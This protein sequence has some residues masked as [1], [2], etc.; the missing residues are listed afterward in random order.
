MDNSNLKNTY[1]EAWR[2]L[3]KKELKLE[4]LDTQT[5][6]LE[7][8]LQYNPYFDPGKVELESHIPNSMPALSIGHR[9]VDLPEQLINEYLKVLVQYDLQVFSVEYERKVDWKTLLEGIYPE[10]LFIDI[11]GNQAC[12]ESFIKFASDLENRT[13]LQ[14]AVPNAYLV[15]GAHVSLDY[16]KYSLEEQVQVLRQLKQDLNKIE[17][18]EFKICVNIDPHALNSLVFLNALHQIATGSG[19]NYII[20]CIRISEQFNESLET[21]LIQA[22]SVAVWASVAKV[23]HIYFNP[24]EGEDQKEY[25]RLILNIQNLL[26]LESKMNNSNYALQGAY[27]IEHLTKSLLDKA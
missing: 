19:K 22:G 9:F 12:I 18:S 1:S 27:V 8:G 14:F 10:M 24:I 25:A 11:R 17:S 16:T 3:L 7:N 13:A 6:I 4:D 15:E 21:G 5:V 23:G 20:E 2:A 26:A